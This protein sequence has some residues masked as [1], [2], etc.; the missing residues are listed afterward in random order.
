MMPG[1]SGKHQPDTFHAGTNFV[2]I[3]ES[4]YVCVCDNAIV[5]LTI[6]D[7]IRFPQSVVCLM[8][9]TRAITTI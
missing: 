3:Y 5:P 4:R 2:N 7:L 1:I 8:K 9:P 6:N